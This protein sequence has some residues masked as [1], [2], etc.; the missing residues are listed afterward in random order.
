MY[1]NSRVI[2]QNLRTTPIVPARQVLRLE[3]A[4]LIAG[5]YVILDAE[6]C[7]VV[8]PVVLLARRNRSFLPAIL[9]GHVL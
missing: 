8:I 7:R 4:R 9:P 1:T 5:P 2:Q 6:D 3:E